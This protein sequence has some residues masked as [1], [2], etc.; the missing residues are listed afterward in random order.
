MS[1][2][3]D[4]RAQRKVTRAAR[5]STALKSACDP[6]VDTRPWESLETRVMMSLVHHYPFNE[7][8]GTATAARPSRNS[9]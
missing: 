7:G 9:G 5:R 2:R 4:L 6:V 1:F 8:T 3:N